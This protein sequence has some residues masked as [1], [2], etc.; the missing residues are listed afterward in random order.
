MQLG[1]RLR[2]NHLS[3]VIDILR[4]S[5]V[6]GVIDHAVVDDRRS[7]LSTNEYVLVIVCSAFSGGHDWFVMEAIISSSTL[8]FVAVPAQWP[9]Q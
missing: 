4:R 9:I 3:I 7:K 5:K 8:G 6:L 2:V 1:T